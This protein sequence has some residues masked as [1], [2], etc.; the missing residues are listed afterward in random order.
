MLE[1]GDTV[2]RVPI[3]PA[4]ARSRDLTTAPSCLIPHVPEAH[5]TDQKPGLWRIRDSIRCGRSGHRPGSYTNVG[6][7]DEV[8]K[9]PSLKPLYRMGSSKRD[10]LSLPGPVDWD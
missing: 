2:C 3:E 5:G 9:S 1:A 4:S 10:L 8:D 7:M 6:I